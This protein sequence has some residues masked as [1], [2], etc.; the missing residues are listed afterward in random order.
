MRPMLHPRLVNGRFGDPAL[1]VET[2]YA[3]ETLLF[4]MGDLAAL[5]PRDLLRI[6]HVFVTHTHMDHFIG[7]DAL[8]RVSVGREKQIRMAGPP[9]FIDRVC[10]K[11]RAYTWDLV[12][13]YETDLIFDVSEVHCDGALVN[14]RL[15]FK[16][17]FRREDITERRADDGVI[18]AEPGFR[19]ETRVLEHHG[20]CLGFAVSEPVHVNIWKSRLRERGL[21]PGP[22]L[23]V[24]KQAVMTDMP[25]SHVIELPGDHGAQSLGGLRDL[26]TVSRGQK[27]AYV[28]DVA[29]TPANRRAI[30]ELAEEA[31]TLFIEARFAAADWEQAR[32]RAHLTTRASG[33][34]AR[35]ARVRR[36]EPF[37][38]SP[39]YEGEEERMIG[40]VLSAF[41]SGPP[42]QAESKNPAL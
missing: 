18:V 1:L 11:L 19:V 25:D 9:G 15:R 4:D 29:D 32:L 40:E 6:S 21:E 12:E 37:H 5:S 39:R 13:R 31:D 38:F 35:A 28:T 36:V 17:G 2:L 10:H 30:A 14:A 34:I 3:R 23:Q 26:V 42:Q 33:E 22:W 27:I 41:Q 7:F 20:P 16:S 8:L 24:L